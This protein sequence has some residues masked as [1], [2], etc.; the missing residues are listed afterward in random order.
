[1]KYI[2]IL[3]LIFSSC[4]YYLNRSKIALNKA[5][6]LFQKN[7]FETAIRYYILAE[8]LNKKEPLN[9]KL[10]KCYQ[11]LG[12][13]K[14]EEAYLVKALDN[15]ELNEFQKL[16]LANLYKTNGSIDKAKHLYQLLLKE[17]LSD[18]V[19][20]KKQISFLDSIVELKN[21][22]NDLP[23][24]VQFVNSKQDDVQP[25]MSGD[26]LFF[27]SNRPLESNQKLV[28]IDK[29]PFFH[30]YEIE[31]NLLNNKNVKKC[32]LNDVLKEYANISA[33]SSINGGRKVYFSSAS[34]KKNS[35]DSVFRLKMYTVEKDSNNGWSK[36]HGFI[37]NKKPFSFGHPYVL[38]DES[39]FFFSSDM[40]GGFGGTDIWVCLNV[41]HIW[42]D[43]INLGPI[44]NTAGNEIY[45]F[46]DSNGKL[47]FSSD[48]HPGFGGYDIHF[49]FEKDGEWKSVEN[50]GKTINT[51]ADEI[52]IFKT[53][54]TTYFTSNRKNGI[55]GFDIYF[56]K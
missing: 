38:P 31:I 25:F 48:F 5:D 24:I 26:T 15:N 40:P 34:D 47:Y 46:H 18:S 28:N 2:L 37:M 27:C 36:P 4:G 7:D 8:K 43:P 35:T 44:I 32:E 41:N 17:N 16:G 21:I 54:N 56:K 29:T 9:L 53:K 51:T 20:Y 14:R 6:V 50:L 23:Q 52:S 42:S 19:Y 22:T 13:K 1:M 39:M 10:S 12:D 33:L 30:F 49:S 11:K 45:P 3:F 55:G